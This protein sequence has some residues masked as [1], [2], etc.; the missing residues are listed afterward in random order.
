MIIRSPS[1]CYFLFGP[2]VPVW[3]I[4]LPISDVLSPL[5]RVCPSEQFLYLFQMCWALWSEC[6]P[7]NNFSTN[8]RCAEPAGPSVPRWTISLPISDVL[9]PL[10]LA[11]QPKLLSVNLTNNL[12]QVTLHSEQSVICFF[13][14][15]H[16][17]F[18]SWFSTLK[19]LYWAY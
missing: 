5:V 1:K 7:L 10:V 3:T 14:R 12:I 19:N 2:S 17:T 15:K 8:F 18:Y 13:N 11:T 4:S 16:Q 9:S 6:A